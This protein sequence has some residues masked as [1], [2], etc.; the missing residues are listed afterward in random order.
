MSHACRPGTLPPLRSRWAR[1]RRQNATQA[2]RAARPAIPGPF[3]KP[4][5]LPIVGA[6]SRIKDRF[7]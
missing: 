2:G 1:W 6:Y 3:G 7:Q 4:W 5:F